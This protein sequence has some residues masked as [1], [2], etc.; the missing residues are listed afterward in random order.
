MICDTTWIFNRLRYSFLLIFQENEISV[1]FHF[2]GAYQQ[3]GYNGIS[4]R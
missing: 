3:Y 1:S 4:L 2:Y